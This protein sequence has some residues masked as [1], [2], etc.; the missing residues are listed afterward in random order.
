M[1]Y[2]MCC[3]YLIVTWKGMSVTV[4]LHISNFNC[5]IVY[6]FIVLQFFS[7]RR[8]NLL[9]W[10]QAYWVFFVNYLSTNTTHV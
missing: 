8:L 1:P 10:S 4:L 3:I 5:N 9:T 2:L 7:L 6:I